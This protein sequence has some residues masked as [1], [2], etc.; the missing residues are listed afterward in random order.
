[1]TQGIDGRAVLW[2]RSVER[3]ASAKQDEPASCIGHR[4]QQRQA[5]KK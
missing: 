2:L 1:M 5:D 4:L 3:G